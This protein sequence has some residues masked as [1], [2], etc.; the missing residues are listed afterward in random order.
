[1]IFH[2]FISEPAGGGGSGI[3]PAQHEA[4]DTLVH[5][6]NETSYQEAT[7]ASGKLSVFTT[8][9]DNLKT[10]KIREISLTYSGNQLATA[11]IVQ[12]NGAGAAVQTLTKT[13]NYTGSTLNSIDLVRT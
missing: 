8:W 7:Y 9:T 5:K 4:L 2:T 10:T 13:F 3:S 1:M 6:I 12:Y 11:T